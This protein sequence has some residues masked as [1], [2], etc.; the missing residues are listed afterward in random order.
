MHDRLTHVDECKSV[1]TYEKSAGSPQPEGASTRMAT[2]FIKP[3]AS[4]RRTVT[5]EEARIASEIIGESMSPSQSTVCGTENLI[6]GGEREFYTAKIIIVL[7]FLAHQNSV[8]KPSRELAALLGF[9]WGQLA[10]TADSLLDGHLIRVARGDPPLFGHRVGA[11][12]AAR[13]GGWGCTW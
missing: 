2:T 8:A 10:S 11:P 12:K 1:Q 7:I 4:K 5:E 3:K 6:T 13:T 9:Y